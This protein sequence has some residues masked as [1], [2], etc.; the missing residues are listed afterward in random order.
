MEIENTCTRFCDHV[1][2]WI[3]NDGRSRKTYPECIAQDSNAGAAGS[4]LSVERSS[5]FLDCWPGPQ[6]TYPTKETSLTRQ[7]HRQCQVL[8]A[9]CCFSLDREERDWYIR[10]C[11]RRC[12][13]RMEFPLYL[14]ST[15]R[16][17]FERSCFFL[18]VR[19]IWA[20]S[21]LLRRTY[22]CFS[23]TYTLKNRT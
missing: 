10:A 21:V 5:Q 22:C 3:A 16:V 2:D 9:C 7:N 13:S 18:T 6:E 4:S 11:H 19:R 15:F 14:I 17:L 1:L 23:R 8:Y 12:A 20:E